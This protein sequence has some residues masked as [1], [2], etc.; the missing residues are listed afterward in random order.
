MH[1]NAPVCSLQG[2]CSAAAAGGLLGTQMA[3][4]YTQPL[5]WRD[6]EISFIGGVVRLSLPCYVLDLLS[7]QS[8]SLY[9]LSFGFHSVLN[10]VKWSKY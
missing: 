8:L 4:S 5:H 6:F 7:S 10:E 1:H 9:I 3:G 2:C